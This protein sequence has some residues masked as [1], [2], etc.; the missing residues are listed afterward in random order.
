[1]RLSS[2]DLEIVRTKP[3]SSELYLSIFTPT[4][5]MAC[6][7]SGTVSNGARTIPYKSVST[8][9]YLSVESGMTLLVGTSAGG[10][11]LGRIRVK[12]ATSSTIVVAENSHIYWPSATHLTVLRYWEMWPIYPRIIP[13]P[14]NDED[15]IFYKD[16]DIAYSSQNGSS[17]LGAFPCAGTH[18]AGYV[19]DQMYYSATGTAHLISGT[20]LTYQWSFEGGNITGSTALTPG[21]VQYNTPGHYVTRLKVTGANGSVDTTYRYVSIYNRPE[22]SNTNVP[23]KKWEIQSL[24]GSRAEGGYSASITIIDEILPTIRDGDVVVIWSDDWYGNNHVSLGGNSPNNSKIFFVGHIV[25]GSI[26]YNYQ[27][28]RTTFD[29]ASVTDIMKSSQGFSVSVESNPTPS[30]WFQLLD[31]DCRRAMYHY[32]KWHSTALFLSDFQFL[33]SDRKIQYFDS[34]RESIFDAVD[35]LMRGTLHGSIVADRQGKLWAE[36][37]VWATPNPTGSFTTIQSITKRDWMDEPTI[38][39]SLTPLLSFLEMGGVAYSGS[40]TGTFSALIGCAPG[41]VPSTKG[42][43][44]R[45][46]GYALTSQSQ[47]NEMV[48]NVFANKNSKYPTINMRMAGNYSHLDIAPQEA[49]GMEIQAID[50]NSGISINAPYFASSISWG[51]DFSRKIKIPSIEFSSIVNGRSGETITIP[52]VPD[53]GGYSGYGG[54]GGFNPGAFP[55]LLGTIGASNYWRGYAISSAVSSG[56]SS[57][58]FGNF[59]DIDG[60]ISMVTSS[61]IGAVVNVSGL[62]IYQAAVILSTATAG[63]VDWVR[64]SSI[65]SL[66]GRFGDLYNFPNQ[67]V[68]GDGIQDLLVEKME[69]GYFTAGDIIK[70]AGGWKGSGSPNTLALRLTIIKVG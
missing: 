12:S 59:T 8:G 47:L 40:T 67:V 26:A 6:L 60:D 22:N 51:I 64:V 34:D 45:Q 10:D 30:K 69:L 65:N 46:Q 62:Y 2:S 43:V 7:V 13:D 63:L 23:I 29:I 20:S 37:D 9:S 25:N 61:S 4:V 57:G 31:M 50:T 49:V 54:F 32:L 27:T 33:G 55:P 36:V 42:S 3:Q 5:A 58:L 53:T 38:Q 28:S 24:A 14:N 15:V 19:G 18:R 16:Y 44:E 41:Q 11:E 66:D 39:S 70:V 48:G 52:E 1:M 17:G 68:Y 35:N 56:G 21:Y